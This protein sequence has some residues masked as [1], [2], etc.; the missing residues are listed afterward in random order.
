M[1]VVS[2]VSMIGVGVQEKE[3]SDVG[4]FLNRILGLSVDQQNLVRYKKCRFRTM[5]LS[6]LF[7]IRDYNALW[8]TMMS[9]TIH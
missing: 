2:D 1:G 9:N 3:A 6:N 7:S 8:C 5:L 4:R